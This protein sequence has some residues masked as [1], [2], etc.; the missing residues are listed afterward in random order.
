MKSKSIVFLFIIIMSMGLQL[1]CIK[2]PVESREDQLETE[3]ISIFREDWTKSS[4]PVGLDPTDPRGELIWYNP[5]SMIATDEIWDSDTQA[6]ESATN[7]FWMEYSPSDTGN[8]SGSWAGIMQRV[9]VVLDREDTAQ[10][11]ELRIYGSSGIIHIDMGSISEDINENGVLDTE[12][13]PNPISLIPNGI[14]D[15]GEDCGLDGLF[16]QWEPGYDPSTNPD[17]NGDNWWYNGFGIK[18]VDCTDDP[19]DYRFINGTEGNALDPSKFGRPDTEDIDREGD[20]DLQNSYVSYKIDLA[21]ND[22]FVI[23][24]DYNG[25]KT[26]RILLTNSLM[27]DTVVNFFNEPSFPMGSNLKCIRIWLES[28]NDEPFSIGLASVDLSGYKSPGEMGEMDFIEKELFIR[29]FQ[30]AYGRIFDLGRMVSN[31]DE[32]GEFDFMAGDSIIRIEVYKNARIGPYIDST[33]ISPAYLYVDTEDTTLFI[34][35]NANTYV[36]LIGP[37]IYVIHPAG[38]WIL[39]N[40]VYG[41]SHGHIG[42]YMILKRASGEI[43]TIGQISEEPYLLKLLKNANPQ[44]S[45]VSW[46]YEWRNVYSI[47][48]N[49]DLTELEINI[50]G[51]GVGSENSD[52]DPDHQHGA[53]FIQILGLDRF[54]SS[55]RPTPDGL[56][57][58]YNPTVFDN[59]GGLLIFPDRKPFATNYEFIDDIILN[60][61]IPEIYN[62]P[63]YHSESVIASKYY[64]KVNYLI[65]DFVK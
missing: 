48:R 7:T 9:R 15:E 4:K 17:P 26:Y 6:G 22:F 54:D 35:E 63:Y 34:T 58:I 14:I 50:Y 3:L 29:D 41:D 65:Y 11:L 16:D 33:I 43:D 5:Y 46:D 59:S 55:G 61:Q 25:W 39:F 21:D 28:Q 60:Y 37:E 13:K 1:A 57:D 8:V 56:V 31:H 40:S 42:Y 38:H 32:P 49:I 52:E 51:G 44:P 10:Y 20:L 64:I 36:R 23:G 47:P 24:S 27:A 45:F 30:Y 19:N 2:S 53:K 62:Y 18:C 12:D